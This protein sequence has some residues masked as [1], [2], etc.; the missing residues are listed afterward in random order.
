MAFPAVPFGPLG[1]L[2]VLVGTGAVNMIV[3]VAGVMLKQE[4]ALEIFVA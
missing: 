3:V 1:K 4:H 2:A